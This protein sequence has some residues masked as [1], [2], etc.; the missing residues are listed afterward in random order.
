MAHRL[1]VFAIIFI[2]NKKIVEWHDYMNIRSKLSDYVI[3]ELRKVFQKSF[4]NDDNKQLE[5]LI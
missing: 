4:K 3:E 5:R 1:K 2:E